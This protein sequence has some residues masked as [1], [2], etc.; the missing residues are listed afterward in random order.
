MRSF[1]HFDMSCS[2]LAVHSLPNTLPCSR[3]VPR[4]HGDS[5][6]MN[7]LHR[8][9][10]LDFGWRNVDAEAFQLLWIGEEGESVPSW[11]H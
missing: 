9:G 1:A 4:R 6:R 11:M 3:L 10:T 2:S 5:L 7:G 8:G